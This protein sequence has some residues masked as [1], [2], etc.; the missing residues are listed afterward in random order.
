MLYWN[1]ISQ[2]RDQ[3]YTCGHCGVHTAA[4]GQYFGTNPVDDK[5]FHRILICSGCSLPTYLSNEMQVPGSLEGRNINHLPEEVESLYK[6]ARLCLTVNAF[7]SS[8]LACRKLLMNI[9]VNEGA[10]EGKNFVFYVDYLATGNFIPP[11]SRVWVDSIRKQG[12][13]ATHSI[14]PKT[15]EEASKLIKLVELILIF[16]YEFTEEHKLD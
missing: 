6:E 9:S 15:K 5:D 7:T 16:N 10:E 4:S 14:T 8:V 3:Y 2:V 12:N 13:E 11:K 1:N